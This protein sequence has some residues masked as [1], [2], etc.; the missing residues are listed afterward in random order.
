MNDCNQ[1]HVVA[2]F[3]FVSSALVMCRLSWL[4]GFSFIITDL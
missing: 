3:F 4:A 1:K 2:G